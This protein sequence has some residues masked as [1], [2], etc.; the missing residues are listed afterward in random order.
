MCAVSETQHL[1]FFGE[2]CSRT[3]V[4]FHLTIYEIASPTKYICGVKFIKQPGSMKH[5]CKTSTFIRAKLAL[6]CQ[7]SAATSL[8]FTNVTFQQKPFCL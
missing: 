4:D 8:S 2:M 3:I 1:I 7:V 6:R 5:F